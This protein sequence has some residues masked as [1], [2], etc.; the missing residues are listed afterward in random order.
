MNWEQL[1]AA[2]LKL[3]VKNSGAPVMVER[4]GIINDEELFIKTHITVVDKYPQISPRTD[5]NNR[6][7]LLIAKPHFDRL[8]AYYL[9]KTQL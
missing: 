4:L 3:N 8:L 9:L 5:A 7:R 1:R 2:L 6:A